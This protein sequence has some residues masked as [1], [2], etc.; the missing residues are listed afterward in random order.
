M[1][2]LTRHGLVLAFLSSLGIFSAKA[3]LLINEVAYKGSSNGDC[4]GEDWIELLNTNEEESVDLTNYV[5]HDDDGADDEDAKVFANITMAPGEFLVLCRNEDFEFGI[6]G[7]DTVTIVDATGIPLSSASLPGS[8]TDGETYAYFDGEYKYTTAATPGEV[9][10]YTAFGDNFRAQNDVGNDFFLVNDTKIFSEVVDIYISLS[11][12]SM[13]TIDDHPSWEKWVSFDELSVFN[14]GDDGTMEDSSAVSIGGEMRVKGQF[15]NFMTVCLGAKNTPFNI[16]FD[17]P[18]M[19]IEKMYLRNHLSDLSYMRDHGS[20]AILQAIGLPYHRTRPARLF[21]NGNYIGFYLVMEAPTQGYV[22]QRNFGAFD[23]GNTALFKIKTAVGQCPFETGDFATIAEMTADGPPPD[24]YY[25]E[26]GEH[27]EDTPILGPEAYT[28]CLNAFGTQLVREQTDVIR[29]F[30]EYNENCAVAM[31]EL[32]RVDR[33]Y[34]PKSMEDAMTTFL[35]KRFYNDRVTDLTSYVDHRQWLQNLAI[36]AI[37]INIDSPL[38]DIINNWY[39]ATFE[40][41]D[42]DWKIV[43]YDHN[44]VTMKQ[45]SQSNCNAICGNRMVYWPIL[46]PTCKSIENHIVVGRLLNSQEN[47]QIYLDYVQEYVNILTTGDVIEKLYDYGHGIKEYVK[48][49]GHNYYSSVE[50]YEKSQLGENIE[51]YNTDASPFLTTLRARLVQVQKQLDA[52]QEGTL[53]RN[54]Q[55]DPEDV[56]PDWRNSNSEGMKTGSEVGEDCTIALC[57]DAAICYGNGLNFCSPEGDLVIEECKPASP[58]CD[59]CFPYSRCGSGTL[60]IESGGTFV[61]SETCGSDLADCKPATECFN[62]NT[63]ICAFDGEI[64][65]V[66]CQPAAS[67][68]KPCFPYSRCGLGEVPTDTQADTPADSSQSGGDESGLF[69]ESYTCG[70]SH[71]SCAN[72]GPCF[73]HALGLCDEDGSMTSPDCRAAVPFCKPCFPKSRCGSGEAG[74]DTAPEFDG[75][76]QDYG[77]SAATSESGA[78]RPRSIVVSGVLALLAAGI[79]WCWMAA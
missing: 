7:D 10:V 55:Y 63:G 8:G 69:V 5:L 32:G 75:P 26:R 16:D 50:D 31:V 73:D 19:G 61:E 74:V 34:G 36:Y 25:F 76:A 52:I 39:L 3:S 41:G 11:E 24:P 59:S 22:M 67:R 56:C 68:C 57:E 49:D 30:R 78:H 40:G 37:M 43:Q 79:S 21:L 33:D 2:S 6:G 47:I 53:P 1:T 28:S 46:Q 23:P 18:F 58:F 54:G 13:T 70:L 27:R 42:N 44:S 17:T 48:D 9:N 51:E 65:T 14:I 64:L 60:L 15:S 35:E 72:S 38:S 71:A 45:S 4:D 29:G 12:E 62:H 20:H 66:E 77:A